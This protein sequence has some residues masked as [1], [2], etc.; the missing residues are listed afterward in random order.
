M[1]A[2]SFAFARLNFF[3]V[4]AS[5]VVSSKPAAT[6]A[7]PT[8]RRVDVRNVISTASRPELWAEWQEEYERSRDKDNKAVANRVLCLT[9]MVE[10]FIQIGHYEALERCKDQL[11]DLLSTPGLDSSTSVDIIELLRKVAFAMT[12][13]RPIGVVQ[14]DPTSKSVVKPMVPHVDEASLVQVS[15]KDS[16]LKSSPLQVEASKVASLDQ[17]DSVVAGIED[18]QEDGT[19]ETSEPQP[20]PEP[21]E[22]DHEGEKK[23]RCSSSRIYRA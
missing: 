4:M 19:T 23:K 9:T 8:S 10:G 7:A 16:G 18:Q 3:S 11:F 20:G 21:D 22:V 14:G 5:R 1:G 6:S 15:D 12:R 17:V 13:K 2:C